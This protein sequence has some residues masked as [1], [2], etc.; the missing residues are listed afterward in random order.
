[1]T[2]QLRI[3]CVRHRYHQ[4]ID[5]TNAAPAT[6]R[7]TKGRFEHGLALADEIERAI[8]PLAGRRILEV[9]AAFG[10]PTAAFLARGAE[11]VGSDRFDFQYSRLSAALRGEPI[12]FLQCDGF[13]HWPFADASFDAVVALELIEMIEDLDAFFGE[14]ARVLRPG[15]C[16]F[17]GT[18]P[19]LK[20]L[21]RDP[22]Y[23]LPGTSAL[24]NRLRRLVATKVFHRG[25]DFR[26]SNHT[27]YSAG[28]FAPA[29]RCCGLDLVPMKFAGSPIMARAAR[30]PMSRLW[31]WLLRRYAFD[32][33]LLRAASTGTGAESDWAACRK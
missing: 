14:M 24:P 17:I 25:S 32:F 31:Q 8:G 22:I 26:L 29:A 21:R 6:R 23:G 13:K 7:W 15:G 18:A 1:M 19:V 3:D 16:G 2:N 28:V 30:W 12:R 20:G 4:A 10:A 33:I 9:G 27:I 5:E 11:C